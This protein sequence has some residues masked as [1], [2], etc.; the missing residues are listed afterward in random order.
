MEGSFHED[1]NVLVLPT[2]YFV[3][4]SHVEPFKITAL[5]W[6]CQSAFVNRHL[7]EHYNGNNKEKLEKVPGI[8]II[9]KLWRIHIYC[10]TTHTWLDER[11]LCTSCIHSNS[12]VKN[13]LL[14]NVSSWRHQSIP[15]VHNTLRL[16]IHNFPVII[17]LPGCCI[18]LEFRR[19][20]K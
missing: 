7:E 17:P 19:S 5:M 15:I 3:N 1:N 4:A 11:Y 16:I 9:Q 18:F 6:K 13:N 20:E 8:V 10:K 14:R 2:I 12:N